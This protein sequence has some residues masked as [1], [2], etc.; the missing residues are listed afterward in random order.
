MMRDSEARLQDLFDTF[1]SGAAGRLLTQRYF[2]N[3]TDGD[4]VILDD[5]GF[6]APG[7]TAA[8][9]HAHE[10]IADLRREDPTLSGEW[11]GWRIEIVNTSGWTVDVLSID[12]STQA[13]PFRH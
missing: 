2:F 10:I 3:L 1:Q 5:T 13:S 6:D 11:A 9:L 7:T 4:E 8:R 12:L